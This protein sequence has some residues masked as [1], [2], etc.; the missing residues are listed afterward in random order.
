[1]KVVCEICEA[2]GYAEMDSNGFNGMNFRIDGFI[3]HKKKCRIYK[4][5][6]MWKN[7]VMKFDQ[8]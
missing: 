7:L 8:S 5:A 1:M 3:K 4:E 6:R 2:K